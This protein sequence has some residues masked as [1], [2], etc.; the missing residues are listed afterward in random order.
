[1][2]PPSPDLAA[3]LDRLDAVAPSDLGPA[4]AAY[5]AESYGAA[6]S[7]LWLVSHDWAALR[8]VGAGESLA[9]ALVNV[10]SSS[11]LA[12]VWRSQ[13][14]AVTAGPGGSLAH[15]PVTYR[16]ERLGVLQ[17]ELPAPPTDAELAGLGRVAR[18]AAGRVLLDGRYADRYERVRRLQ[19]FNLPAELQSVL[20]PAR[21]C[22]TAHFTLAAQVIP[23][24]RVGGDHFDYQIH[25]DGVTVTVSDAMGHGLDAAMVTTLGVG[26]LR[27]ARRHRQPPAEQFGAAND[28]LH[29]RFGGEKFMTALMVHVGGE[30]ALVVQAGHPNVTR[31]RGGQA[32][33]LDFRPQ[34]PLGL[35][36][37]SRYEAQ[38]VDLVAGDRLVLVSDGTLEAVDG[39]GEQFAD[40]SFARVLTETAGGDPHATVA[41]LQQALLDHQT[42]DLRDD[43][44]I[45]CLDWHPTWERGPGA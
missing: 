29:E 8:A 24:A 2:A 32:V 5:L 39:D 26:A 35:F 15:L 33:P 22:H 44:T 9:P 7:E 23:A 3:L 21:G 34:L 41:A 11:P 19:P 37:T 14:A 17:V 30:G 4:L 43:A 45:V 12:G 38:A 13:Q 10:R 1:M 40:R 18:T 36:P 20:L 25:P 28:A 27:H 42:G 6:R 16:G 31:V